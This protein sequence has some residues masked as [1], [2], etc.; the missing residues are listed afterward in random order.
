[1]STWIPSAEAFGTP[2]QVLVLGVAGVPSAEAFGTATVLNTSVTT[3]QL[4]G[5]QSGEAFGHPTQ[6]FIADP[7]IPS[8]EAFGHPVVLS[9]NH[10]ILCSATARGYGRLTIGQI[11]ASGTVVGTG[12]LIDPAILI[13]WQ[14]GTAVGHGQLLWNGPSV[15]RGTGTL[16][17]YMEVAQA[18]RSIHHRPCNVPCNPRFRWGQELSLG[19]LTLHLKDL[20]DTPFIPYLVNY[21]LYYVHRGGWAQ[22]IGATGR[23][24]VLS[25]H[26]GF[27][28]T[29]FAGEGGQ[30]G[31]WRI[32]WQWQR[33]VGVPLEEFSYDFCVKDAVLAHEHRDTTPRVRKFGWGESL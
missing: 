19:D 11:L 30:P 18:P 25:S 5:I 13:I 4:P 15:I 10:V 24:P 32:K 26:F 1:M 31:T 16:L 33:A 23:T 7:G 17:A 22:Q 2:S 12:T 27:Y 9:T 28:A 14:S 20:D 6:I 3:I 29:G 21:T 8:A